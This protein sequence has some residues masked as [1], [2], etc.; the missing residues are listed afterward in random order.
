MAPKWFEFAKENI[1]K[2]D[3]I[4]RSF[5]GKLDGESGHLIMSK[6]KLLFIHEE[7][8]LHKKFDV[9]LELP[10]DKIGKVW[11]EGEYELDLTEK[12]GKKHVLKTPEVP[13]KNIEKYL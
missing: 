4:K 5:P 12:D 9:A 10:Y 2:E 6:K 3:E 13:V 7:G 11:H 8:F 1:D